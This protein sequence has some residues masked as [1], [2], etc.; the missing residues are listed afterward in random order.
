MMNTITWFFL[1]LLLGVQF[2]IQNVNLR[3]SYEAELKKKNL[4]KDSAKFTGQNKVLDSIDQ[5]EEITDKLYLSKG[6]PNVS[7][8][9][10][11]CEEVCK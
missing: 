5:V 11:S 2:L 7:F 8:N 3:I 10:I 6:I 4:V 9:F 1:V